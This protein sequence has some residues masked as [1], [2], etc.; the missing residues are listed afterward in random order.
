MTHQCGVDGTIN[1][2]TDP[3]DRFAMDFEGMTMF[4]LNDELKRIQSTCETQLETM[5]NEQGM[6]ESVIDSEST[7]AD[8][9][10]ELIAKADLEGKNV[11]IKKST[12]LADES[13]AKTGE[14]TTKLNSD[15][16]DCTDAIN[17]LN[18][19]IAVQEKKPSQDQTDEI[20]DDYFNKQKDSAAAAAA[21]IADADDVY[22]KA[23]EAA[24]KE[25]DTTTKPL[26]ETIASSCPG[27]D[28]VAK[29]KAKKELEKADKI[30]AQNA[31]LKAAE[32]EC[33]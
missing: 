3:L 33:D 24:Q 22:K 2:N 10:Q 30:N 6:L 5:T 17:D 11:L 32:E 8:E 28:G 31:K 20:E 27:G 12:T 16:A 26:D 13:E 9:E 15:A 1:H 7:I 29:M 19:Q 14:L 23:M 18:N 25:F 21:A 4:A